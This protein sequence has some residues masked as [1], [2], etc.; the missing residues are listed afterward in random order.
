[1]S[2]TR[3]SSVRA[4]ASRARMILLMCSLALAGCDDDAT[5]P[6][7]QP[8]FPLLAGLWRLDRANGVEIPG[9]EIARRLIGVLDEQTVLDSAWI[10]VEADGTWEQRYF[11]QVFHNAVF[12]RSEV[13]V[14]R[15]TWTADGNENSFVSSIRT[16][17]FPLMV[18]QSTHTVSAEQMV[19]FANAPLVTGDY[20]LVI[21][22]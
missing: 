8:S 3:A 11:L 14:D 5:A 2:L 18:I 19:F 22:P 21:T 16:R 4:L 10:E 9:A 15:G 7:P 17:S 13:V 20:R 6:P 12:D 1:M